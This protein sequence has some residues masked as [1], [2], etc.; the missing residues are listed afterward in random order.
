MAIDLLLRPPNPPLIVGD[1]ESLAGY[2][3]LAVS[4]D[5]ARGAVVFEGDDG[6]RRTAAIP[7]S[8]AAAIASAKTMLIIAL[9][10]SGGIAWARREPL[11]IT[12]HSGIAELTHEEIAALMQP[13]ACGPIHRAEI[14]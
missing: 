7:D 3:G 11:C 1:R 13:V 10:E 14:D 6:L 9:D 5:G 12:G 4:P 2:S 8:F